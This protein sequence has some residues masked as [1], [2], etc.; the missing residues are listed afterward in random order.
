MSDRLT[1]EGAR[2]EEPYRQETVDLAAQASRE[3]WKTGVFF[4]L[5]FWLPPLY[6]LFA[7]APR[8]VRIDRRRKVI[9]S[10]SWFS[11]YCFR[12]H[13]ID[14]SELDSYYMSAGPVIAKDY[15]HGPLIYDL[16]KASNPAKTRAFVLGRG[17]TPV[18]HQYSLMHNA[19]AQFLHSRKDPEWLV[20]LKT[21]PRGRNNGIDYLAA[22]ANFHLIAARWPRST[23][24]RLDRFLEQQG[25]SA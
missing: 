10:W 4:L 17:P 21:G 16:P 12:P 18:Y 23:G 7:P 9:Y 1:R 25:K 22:F 24:R 20:N 11:L 5:A 3:E 2:F 15:A 19:A 6:W 13:Q 8:G 14:L